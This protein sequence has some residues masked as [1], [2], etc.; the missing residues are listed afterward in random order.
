MYVVVILYIFPSCLIYTYIRTNIYTYILDL[1]CSSKL[2]GI[3][4]KRHIS[5]VKNKVTYEK[6]RSILVFLEA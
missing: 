4:M 3:Y 2:N 6:I 5:I 1:V